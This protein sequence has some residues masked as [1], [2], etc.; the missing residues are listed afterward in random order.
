MFL[1]AKPVTGSALDLLGP[2]PWYILSVEG[3]GL[4]LFL[5]L[6]LPFRKA[7]PDASHA[8]LPG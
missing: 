1:R 6:Y 5:L 7:A 8:P 3:M 4:A 2:W